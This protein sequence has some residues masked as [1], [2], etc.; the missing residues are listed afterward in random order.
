M[1]GDKWD[2]ACLFTSQIQFFENTHMLIALSICKV[3][4][5]SYVWGKAL[6]LVEKNVFNI[7]QKG[8]Y[9]VSFPLWKVGGLDSANSASMVA[10]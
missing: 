10:R 6:I 2:L 3:P 9:F 5:S 1:F 8:I 7:F 4:S